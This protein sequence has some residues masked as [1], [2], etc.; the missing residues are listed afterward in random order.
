MF[1]YKLVASDLDGTLLNNKSEVSRENL[2]AIG[3][4]SDMGVMFIPSTG[5]T[6]A[7]MP[8]LI[9]NNENIRY[10]IY[11]NGTVVY[12]KKTGERILN[13]ISNE[14]GRKVLDIAREYE[15]H[16]SFRCNGRCYVDNRFQSLEAWDYYN[17]CR[18]HR[19]VVENFGILIEDFEEKIDNADEIEVYSFFFKNLSEK[20]ECRRRISGIEGIAVTGVTEYNIEVFNAAAGKGNALQVL[21]KKLGIKAE[22]T[23][24]IGDSNNDSTI[25][26]ASG[27]G[28]AVSNACDSLKAVA[29]EIICSNEE[30]VAKFV[31][32]KY[33]S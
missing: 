29:D 15:V 21:A 23:I 4:L 27:L 28:L 30:H 20:E 12:D 11:S 31:L 6:F 13:C 9:R 25:L 7:E 10:Y 33:F 16:K 32:E 8:R 19:V 1:K 14:T 26:R 5:R 22:E 17:V 18:E 2:D 3:K 24:S